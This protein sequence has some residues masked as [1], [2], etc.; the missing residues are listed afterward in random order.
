MPGTNM[1]AKEPDRYTVGQILR[2]TEGGLFPVSCPEDEQ[3]QC[4]R[5]E[6]C[7]TLLLWR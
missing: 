7:K 4:K 2:L 5:M 6:Y 3:N 1:L